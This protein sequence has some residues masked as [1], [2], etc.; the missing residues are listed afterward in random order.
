MLRLSN[1][2]S[3]SKSVLYLKWGVYIIGLEH[4]R[5]KKF[6]IQLLIIHPCDPT[7]V[8]WY[9]IW[10]CDIAVRITY[11]ICDVMGQNQSHVAKHETSKICILS[12]NVKICPIFVFIKNEIFV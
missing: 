6:R 12:E 11:L 1:F 3:C 4:C 7:V 5:K 2:A 9:L 10:P 8:I